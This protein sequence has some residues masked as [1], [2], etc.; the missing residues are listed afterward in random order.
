MAAPL[1]GCT[2]ATPPPKGTTRRNWLPVGVQQGCSLGSCSPPKIGLPQRLDDGGRTIES[3]SET[4]KSTSPILLLRRR[5]TASQKEAS[6]L[7]RPNLGK[8]SNLGKC[9][10]F[11]WI[12]QRRRSGLRRARRGSVAQHRG[13]IARKTGLRRVLSGLHRALLA[14]TRMDWGS[15]G[16]SMSLIAALCAHEARACQLRL[17]AAL[18]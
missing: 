14:E 12:S 6:R 17:R 16:C 10:P 7:T 4:C 3:A 13:C 2:L 9:Y 18:N 11:L 1:V 5:S 8:S 15:P